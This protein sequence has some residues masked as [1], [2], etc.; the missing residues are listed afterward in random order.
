MAKDRKEIFGS[1]TK[2]LTM[3]IEELEKEFQERLPE[4]KIKYN[5]LDEKEANEFLIAQMYGEFKRQFASPAKKFQGIF[6]GFTG[7]Q[8]ADSWTRR[9]TQKKVDELGKEKALEQ[10]FTNEE[11]KLLFNDKDVRFK[12]RHG[13]PIPDYTPQR[14][15]YG[16]CREEKGDLVPFLMYD[17]QCKKI[18]VLF[19]PSDFRA[20][21]KSKAEDGFY[22]MN[23]ASITDYKIIKDE[24]I[25]FVEYSKKY[26]REN[27]VSLQNLYNGQD[28][29]KPSKE[30]KVSQFVITRGEVPKIVITEGQKADGRE[31][32][33]VIELSEMSGDMTLEKDSKNVAGFVNKEVPINFAE[34]GV[35]YV[36]GSPFLS[37]E[38]DRMMNVFGIWPDPKYSIIIPDP[39]EPITKENGNNK[40]AP[41]EENDENWA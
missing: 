32:N 16:I 40:S 10:G 14:R 33:N 17:G 2:K 9:E 19:K 24:G 30:A 18:P 25:D 31:K 13:K 7:I 22:Q 26:F 27:C 12:W 21:S 20:N 28:V 37:K 3:S 1:W 38:G 41:E 39:E 36:I 34:G 5:K 11:G 6:I 4:V 23:A 35:A 15:L 8:D 29:W